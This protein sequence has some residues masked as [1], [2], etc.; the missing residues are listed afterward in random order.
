MHHTERTVTKHYVVDDQFRAT[1][2]AKRIME[3]MVC[4]D[5]VY[6]EEESQSDQSK[7]EPSNENQ[8][9]EPEKRKRRESSDDSSSEEETTKKGKR[10][11][12][13][14]ESSDESSDDE[15][16]RNPGKKVQIDDEEVGNRRANVQKTGRLALSRTSTFSKEE[17]EYIRKLFWVNGK[18]P[19]TLSSQLV[20]SMSKSN[21]RFGRIYNKILE[22]KESEPSKQSAKDRVYHAIR[23]CVIG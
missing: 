10:K 18:P 7:A 15:K 12:K 14:P 3:E 16:V 9:G 1:Y 23:K 5:K 22:R 13:T 20:L 17:R 8:K 2:F 21:V 4:T 19:K 6:E 11:R